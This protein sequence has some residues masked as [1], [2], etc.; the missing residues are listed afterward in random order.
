MCGKVLR[1]INIVADNWDNDA[2]FQVP[3]GLTTV[4]LSEQFIN[5]MPIDVDTTTTVIGLSCTVVF[6]R[7]VMSYWFQ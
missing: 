6:S 5:V 7:Y 1:R 4:Q 3:I 2:K